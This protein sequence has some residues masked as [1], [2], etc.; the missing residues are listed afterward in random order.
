MGYPYNP[1]DPTE[2][3][4]R[5][6][7][8]LP[9]ADPEGEIHCIFIHQSLKRIKAPY[10]AFS[11]VWG[12]SPTVN[13]VCIED[14]RL[15]VQ[16]NLFSALKSW[17]DKEDV[18]M[19]WADALCINQSDIPERNTQVA[20]MAAIYGNAARV[21]MWLGEASDDSDL[22][23]DFFEV[24]LRGF[25]QLE[26]STTDSQR[27]E[28]LSFLVD[29]KY[30]RYWRA[31][32]KFLRYEYWF[33]LW[34]VQEVILATEAFTLCGSKAIM[35]RQLALILEMLPTFPLDQVSTAAEEAIKHSQIAYATQVAR[36]TDRRCQ[37]EVL[38]MYEGLMFGRSRNA[39]EP[40]DY[41]YGILGIVRPNSVKPDY[42]KSILEV[43]VDSVCHS[44]E[45]DGSANVLTGCKG[46]RTSPQWTVLRL[47]DWRLGTQEIEHLLPGFKHPVSKQHKEFQAGGKQFSGYKLAGQGRILILRGVL[48]D[49][50]CHGSSKYAPL[51]ANELQDGLKSQWTGW[52]S[53][54]SQGQPYGDEKAQKD[55]FARTAI[56]GKLYAN[57]GD[58]SITGSWTKWWDLYLG[59]TGYHR[60]VSSE[61]DDLDISVGIRLANARF[62]A[63][64]YFT[65]DIGY[66]GRGPADTQ[67]GDIVC[68]FFGA[69][70]PFIL[71]PVPNC[72]D[73]YC[74][75]GECCKFIPD[76]PWPTFAD[77][78][79]CR[80]NHERRG[81]EIIGRWHRDCA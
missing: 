77:G 3:E 12:Q 36:L 53:N 67:R 51:T 10:A 32:D 18:V 6:L 48:I 15:S 42:A 21:W 16:P 41:L 70:V 35:W 54:R 63:P 17:R 65:T 58:E 5:I 75:L 9:S 29:S 44:F 8:I 7:A 30:D 20:L 37:G 52:L 26:N 11:Y 46:S 62:A 24:I 76:V 60:P 39:T 40:R 4:I 33:R 28:A 59:W 66:M 13:T 23:F 22:A 74:L 68:I 78:C 50:V 55:A 61:K 69:D 73:R 19:V 38:A 81:A 47:P 1:L 45:V 27:V 43:F 56:V 57:K 25:H 34:I 14:H 80:W 72:D 31:V 2:D 49:A 71:R 64:Q 79:R